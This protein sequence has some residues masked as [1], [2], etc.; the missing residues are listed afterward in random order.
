MV[1]FLT[2]D[3][4]LLGVALILLVAI[5]ACF[6]FMYRNEI[7]SLINR[8]WAPPEAVKSQVAQQPSE[9]ATLRATFQVDPESKAAASVAAMILTDV[10]ASA[11]SQ[12]EK[13]QT[14]AN[15]AANGFLRAEFEHKYRLIY[16]SQLEA[17]TALRQ[18]G[19]H[20]LDEHY[21]V[22][23]KRVEERRSEID[24]HGVATSFEDWIQFLTAMKYPYVVLDAGI[25]SITERGDA[26]MEYASKTVP[27]NHI[28]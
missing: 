19:P 16:K 15:L 22:F 9:T 21:Q 12:D 26:F 27:F 11:S 10:L 18:R 20:A 5:I 3:M 13:M 23:L 2:R 7:R 8:L 25:A 24:A 6:L 28:L 17:L 1:S 4:N 14:L